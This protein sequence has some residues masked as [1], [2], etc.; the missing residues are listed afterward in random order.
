MP[1]AADSGLAGGGLPR[2]YAENFLVEGILGSGGIGRVYLAV[3]KNLGREVAIKE[4]IA[5]KL[6]IHRDR[7]IARFVREAR[8]SGQLQHPGIVPVYQL[9]SK[10]DGSFFYVMKRVQ[11][12]TLLQAIKEAADL[13]P[14]EAYRKRLSLLGELIA[15]ADAMG[16][17][18]ARGVIHRDL[19]PS[20]I[21]LGEFGETVILDWGLAKRLG[22][23]S[24][25]P[26]GELGGS[27]ESH[28]EGGGEEPLKTRDG[29]H[30]G[31]PPYMAPEQ[32]DSR[33][34]PVGPASDV[35]A[36]GGML[37]MLLAG[38]RPYPGRGMEVMRSIASDEPSPSPRAGRP[39]VSPELAAICERAMAK[40]PARRFRSGAEFAAELRAFRDGRLVGVYAYS[41]M[42]LFRRFVARN[43][44]PIAAAIAVLLSIVG[45]AGYALHFASEAHEARAR[46]ERA[47][48]DVTDLSDV[49]MILAEKASESLDGFFARA[50]KGL[51]D[52]A[53]EIGPVG[54]AKP[55]RLARSL[56]HLKGL[57]PEAAAAIAISP[58]GKLAAIAP[59]G[60]WVRPSVTPELYDRLLGKLDGWRSAVGDLFTLEGTTERA[61]AV[62]A[63]AGSPAR[64]SGIVALLFEVN[65]AMP[66]ALG[67]DARTTSHQVWCMREDGYI[68]YDEDPAQI[69]KNLFSDVMYAGFPE[70][71]SFGER[72]RAE[73][74]GVGHYA[75]R[76]PSEEGI[77]YKVAAWDS[78]TPAEGLTWKVVISHSYAAGSAP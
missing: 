6:G 11:G 35:Y 29:A 23:D 15:V 63:P 66:V 42:E 33:F 44:M 12:R 49:T 45:G 32:V 17:A 40:D 39:F 56:E 61:F 64:S 54:L 21:V 4:L 60:S 53:E 8:V 26:S 78:F 19:K 16:Y 67:F 73:P 37:F 30:L 62:W 2:P 22:D 57:H 28:P 25:E 31:T 51:A 76:A 74:W 41:R 5:E 55:D 1:G 27:G 47:L 3:E 46:A 70:L 72:I 38:E 48:A 50:G 7:T 14:E 65:R 36:L 59:A 34:G 43:R 58:P 77:N 69:G 71:L 20:N 68:F 18:H 9:S 75:F 24:L 13:S 10:P 52:A